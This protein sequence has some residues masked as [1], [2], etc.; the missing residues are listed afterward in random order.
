MNVR[1]AQ[2]ARD[3]RLPQQLLP[4]QPRPCFLPEEAEAPGF[5]P[6]LVDAPRV[7]SAG[8]GSTGPLARSAHHL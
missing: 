8:I 6:H 4:S 5:E 3:V 7:L 2:Q 1:P